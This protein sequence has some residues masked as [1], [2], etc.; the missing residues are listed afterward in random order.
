MGPLETLASVDVDA[1]VMVGQPAAYLEAIGSEADSELVLRRETTRARFPPSTHYRAHAARIGSL[2]ASQDSPNGQSERLRL[3]GRTR[4]VERY[5]GETDANY[6]ERLAIAFSTHRKAGTPNA[7]I[8]QL[9][10]F[11]F[12]DVIV[13]EEYA[14][15]F[16]AEPTDEYGWRFV[17]VVGPNFGSVAWSGA[18]VG[19]AVVGTDTV[20]L[21]TGTAT[22]LKAIKLLIIK[23]KQAFAI[24]LRFVIVFGD[25]PI[26]GLAIV[27][28]AIVGGGQTTEVQMVD[29]RTV[30]TA[31]VGEA[32][33]WGLNL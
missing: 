16:Y 10:A 22:Q 2:P 17:V 19:T 12:V 15:G 7:I 8:D 11:G 28:G 6:C 24:P 20:G 5:P 32:P 13:F 31:V 21:G 29:P 26:V 27:G 30:G 25:A 14:G 23:W 1:R 33:L 18:I 3:I 9:H 4:D